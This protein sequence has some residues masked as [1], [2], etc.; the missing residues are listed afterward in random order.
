[1]TWLG[2]VLV[3]PVTVPTVQS[4]LE[5]GY[6]EGH[7]FLANAVDPLGGVIDV[8]EAGTAVATPDHSAV[9]ERGYYAPVDHVE[10]LLRGDD[11]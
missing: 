5:R 1:V 10:E 6:E 9:R 11:G 7:A 4:E 2:D 8:V 3:R